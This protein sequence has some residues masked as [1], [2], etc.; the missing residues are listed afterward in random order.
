MLVIVSYNVGLNVINSWL[1][2]FGFDDVDVFV[3]K[4]FYL[5]IRGYVE[6]V[7]ENYWN[8]LQIYNFEVFQLM[9]KYY[10]KYN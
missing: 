6:F 7:F 2:C 8:Y 10:V 1:K 9:E 5:E 4:I 3:E